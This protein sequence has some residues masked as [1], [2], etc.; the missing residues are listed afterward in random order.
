MKTQ[1]IHR[2]T[3]TLRVERELVEALL[4]EPIKTSLFTLEG[5]DLFRQAFTKALTE[6]QRAKATD[7]EKTRA[8][9]AEVEQEINHIN[10]RNQGGDHQPDHEAGAGAGRS[11]ARSSEGIPGG[12]TQAEGT[13]PTVLPDFRAWFKRVAGDLAEM[14]PH[15]VDKAR[16]ILKDLVGSITLKP[17]TQG[18]EPV[19]VAHLQPDY[20]GLARQ[21]VGPKIILVSVFRTE[22][23]HG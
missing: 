23:Q 13:L 7:Q 14:G 16:G 6:R 4:L 11:R 12:P 19:L 2:C 9:L 1:G 20:D 17:S 8:R 22:V 15:Q 10:G 5:F 18:G 3:N 21:L